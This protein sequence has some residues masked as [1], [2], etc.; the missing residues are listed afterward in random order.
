MKCPLA[1]NIL[2]P[3]IEALI[4]AGG[5]LSSKNPLDT[6]SDNK[7]RSIRRSNSSYVIFRKTLQSLSSEEIRT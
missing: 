5:A 2:V 4:R 1:S 6:N 7:I 3:S